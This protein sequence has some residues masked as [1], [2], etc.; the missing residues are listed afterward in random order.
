MIEQQIRPWNVLAMQ[1]L[2]ALGAIRREDF[3]PE[4]YR[5]LSFADVQ[6][7]LGNGEVML[8]PKLG[9]RMVEALAL[10]ST[11]KVLEIGTGS[12]YLTALLATVSE[13]VT[14]IEIDADLHR[15]AGLNLAV[16]GIENVDLIHADCHDFCNGSRQ[17]DAVLIGGSVPTVGPMFIDLIDQTGRLIGIEGDEPAMHVVKYT[18]SADSLNKVY[19]LETSV[20]RLHNVDEKPEFVF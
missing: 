9:A 8:E 2:T 14:S 18:K 10:V 6:I 13:H 19:L 5:E 1:T 11:D 16:S 3:V 20:K 15:Q 17:Y 4:A 7:P 12:G